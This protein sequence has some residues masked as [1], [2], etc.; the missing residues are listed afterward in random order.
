M[1]E[2]RLRFG[3][4]V[5]VISAIGIGIILTFLFGAF[6]SVLNRDYTLSVVF[7]SSEGI[8]VN[9]P[10]F[11]DGVRIGRVSDIK[12]RNEGGVLVMLAMDSSQ[13]L[14]HNFIPRIG[15]GN[16]VTGDSKLEFVKANAAE[17]NSIFPNDQ[18]IISTP[19][20]DEE[21]L[22]YGKK[23]P[24]L[25]DM[26]NDMQET[27]DAIRSAGESIA[28]AGDSV[29]QLAI[30]V[31]DVVGGADSK[32]DELAEQAITTLEDF[33]GAIGDVRAIVGNP[34]LRANLEQSLAELPELIAEAQAA[35][36]SA[37]TTFESFERVGNQFERVGVAAE[38][39]VNSVQNAVDS[40][41]QTV[42]NL[43]QFTEPLAER[44]DELV[45]QVM[46]SLI[47]I[48][49]ALV[50]VEAFAKTLNN[51]DGSLKRFLEDDD[52]YFQFRRTIE[53]VEQASAKIR[54]ILDDVRIFTDKVAR[55]PRELG[56]RGALGKRPSGAGYK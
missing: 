33:Q 44:G 14:T 19:Y 54:P 29:N 10:V 5:L 24:S 23:S 28:V 45:A 25:L 55:D 7:P 6:P 20:S 26:Q 16:F 46:N 47:S 2:N 37:E 32:V 56:V 50:Q 52:I 1:D 42:D 30:E 36:D 4:G 40:V 31:R 17:L 3:V 22:D 48:D 8:S 38:E 18:N 35:F 21:F 43:E 39:T 9:S 49:D 11:R 51:S 41:Q 27:F 34:E 13:P 15:S 12:L 53:N